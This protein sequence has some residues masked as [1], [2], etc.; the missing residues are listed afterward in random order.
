MARYF[1]EYDL[2]EGADYQQLF[3][4]LTK[5]G[6]KKHLLSAWHLDRNE[7]GQSD[8]LLTYLLQFIPRGS[9]LVVSEI[10]DCSQYNAINDPRAGFIAANPLRVGGL[11]FVPNR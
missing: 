1:V 7:V 5:L 4:A 11:G 2:T 8:A 6:A 3:D 9:R 10:R